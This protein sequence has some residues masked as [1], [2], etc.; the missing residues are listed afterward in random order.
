M[1]YADLEDCYAK[2][3][4]G[5]LH[6][7]QQE[8][9]E[10]KIVFLHGF[11]ASAM[12]WSRLA[13]SLPEEMSFYLLDLLGH[14]SSDAPK[15]NYTLDVQARMV[16]EFAKEKGAEDIYLFGNSYGA[17]IAARIAQGNY[18][19]MGIVLE[20]AVGLKEYFDDVAKKGDIE[21]YKRRL[22]KETLLTNPNEHVAESTI[23]SGLAP[24]VFLTRESLSSIAKPA[25][26]IWGSE[27][28]IVD[29]KYAKMLSDYIKGSTLE[30]VHGAGHVPH[31][32]HPEA[33]RDLLLRFVGYEA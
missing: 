5:R 16:Q 12:S 27:D 14:G 4:L 9:G 13:E 26:I 7:K 28:T 3:S 6:Y 15:I 1:R 10:P 33:V 30:I 22:I 20:D 25:L 24:G 17:W 11:G 23:E 21:A 32:T 29:V 2:T 19:G 31:F 8:G 18:K